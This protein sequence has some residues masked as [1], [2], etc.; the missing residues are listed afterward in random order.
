M[1]FELI[2]LD[3]GIEEN[4]LNSGQRTRT[5]MVLTAPKYLL[6]TYPVKSLNPPFLCYGGFK[7][8]NGYKVRNFLLHD[9]K[10]ELITSCSTTTGNCSVPFDFRMHCGL[11]YQFFFINCKLRLDQKIQR[12]E[13]IMFR[14][15]TRPR[16]NCFSYGCPKNSL[17]RHGSKICPGN[18]SYLPL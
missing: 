9:G 17:R 6:K 4:I 3:E 18:V 14:W 8:F 1:E 12:K 2:G 15:E 16:I 11:I 7:L 13:K 10:I 5:K